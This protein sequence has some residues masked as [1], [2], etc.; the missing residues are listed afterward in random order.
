M[1][2][3]DNHNHYCIYCGEKL[4]PGQ[5]FC[6]QCGKEI[7]NEEPVVN[8]VSSKYDDKI[9]KIE[10]E[11]YFKEKKA[12]EVVD[13]LFDPNHMA[14]EKFSSSINRSNQ[15]F[16][17]QLEVTKKMVGLNVDSNP[18]VEKEIDNKI[19][20]LETFIDKMDD[21]INELVIHLSS[22]KKDND[23]INSLFNDMDDLINSVKDY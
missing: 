12:R 14:H 8:V 4:D 15:L 20:I 17:N 21:L 19:G 3:N 2:I 22:N 9:E 11:Y 13:K 23:D 7:Y 18:A 6:S 5:R 16:T 1:G 10:Q